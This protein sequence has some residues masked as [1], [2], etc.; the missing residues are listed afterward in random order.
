VIRRTLPDLVVVPGGVATIGS[1]IREIDAAANEWSGRLL[2]PDFTR[3]RLRSWLMKEFPAHEV[4]IP[5][6][7]M[8][9]DP[10]T[11][12]EYARFVDDTGF[13]VPLS[14]L[15]EPDVPVWGVDPFAAATFCS[16]LSDQLGATV[17]L[18]TESEWEWAARGPQARRYPWGDDFDASRCNTVESGLRVPSP[19]GN[20]PGGDSW[21]GLRDLAGNVEEWVATLYEPYPGGTAIADDL[22]DEHPDGYVVL[23]GGSCALSGDAARGARRH[24][25]PLPGERY[26]YTGFRV[27]VDIGDP[28]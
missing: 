8:S 10:V 23:R 4:D 19:A 25:G 20:H 6:F 16:W 26:Q 15:D 5:T 7:R 17:R 11:Q 14:G 1:S 27:A 2:E 24:G 12:S 3:D 9:R 18:P 28:R 21:C 13:S 22:A